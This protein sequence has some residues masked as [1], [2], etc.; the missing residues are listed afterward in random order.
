MHLS[1]K[2]RTELVMKNI[3]RAIPSNKYGYMSP[4]GVKNLKAEANIESCA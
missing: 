1:S 4:Q 3:R 2:V